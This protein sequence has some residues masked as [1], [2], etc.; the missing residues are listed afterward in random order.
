MRKKW[1]LFVPALNEIE[2]LK[3][4][5]P[6]IPDGIFDQILVVDGNSNDGT[7]EYCTKMGFD[8]LVQTHPGLRGAFIDGFKLVRNEYVLTF[9]PD[10]NCTSE[11]VMKIVEKFE[12]E[13]YDMVI[14]SR[15]LGGNRSGDDDL[16]TAFGNWLFTRVINWVHGGS[17]TDAMTIFRGYKTKIFYAL[18]ID[19]DESYRM[20]KWYGTVMGCEPLISIRAA[21]AKLKTG[22]VFSYECARDSGDRKLQIVRWGLAYMTQVFIE[23]VMWRKKLPDLRRGLSYEKV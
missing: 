18:D 13:D 8:V 2:G 23:A 16:I 19:K 5:M 14:A 22:E 20:E 7:V 21:K 10:G 4:N 1:T 15:Y 6:K 11:D 3:E 17:Y 12:E 9:S